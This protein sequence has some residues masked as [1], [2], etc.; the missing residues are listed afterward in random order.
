[1]AWAKGNQLSEV[2]QARAEFANDLSELECVDVRGF[3]GLEE[4]ENA[5]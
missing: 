4:A 3:Y 1:M 2:D 5:E